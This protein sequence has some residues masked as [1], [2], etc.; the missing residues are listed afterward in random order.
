MVKWIKRLWSIY[1]RGI[2]LSHKNKEILPFVTT[3][4]DP[5]GIRLSEII[6]TKT[7]TV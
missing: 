6:W 2:L 3:W 4:I 1:A 5:E 7:N